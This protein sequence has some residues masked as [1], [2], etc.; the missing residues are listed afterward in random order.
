MRGVFDSPLVRIVN[1]GVTRLLDLPVLGW[2]MGRTMATVRY[3]GRRS[4]RTFELPVGYRR[5]GDEIT[6][7]VQFPDKKT[8]WRNFLGEG[9]PITMQLDGADRAGHAIA[10]RDSAGRVSVRVQLAP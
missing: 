8:W 6:I 5:S 7:A 9:G 10:G 4:G 1:A 3:T 2:L